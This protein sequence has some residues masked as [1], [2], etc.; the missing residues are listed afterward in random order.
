M[1]FA[2]NCGIIYKSLGRDFVV[3]L[4]AHSGGNYPVRPTSEKKRMRPKAFSFLSMK[5]ARKIRIEGDVAYVPLTKGLEAIIDA[6][7]V[8]LVD[9]FNWFA[10]T[11]THTSYARRQIYF[12]S[13]THTVYMHRAILGLSDGVEGDH[14][15]GNGLNNRRS[16]LREANR[17][18]NNQN[19]RRHKN[20]SSGIKGVRFHEKSGRWLAK[21]HFNGKSL[22]LGSFLSEEEASSA[23]SRESDRLHAEFKRQN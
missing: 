16:N 7:D 10:H 18:Q 9:G 4:R 13:K 22:H 17:A 5:E 2:I 6:A 19:R 12:G 8:G 11:Q 1:Q 14:I 15:D 20:N 23:Y 21:I 3:S